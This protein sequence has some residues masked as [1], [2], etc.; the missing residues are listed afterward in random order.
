MKALK[1]KISRR[2]FLHGAALTTAGLAVAA[3]TSATPTAAPTSAPK[4]AEPSATTAPT[5][6][7]EATTAPT[8]AV[9]SS[10][11]DSMFPKG[12]PRR[13]LLDRPVPAPKKYDNL[14]ITQNYDMNQGIKFNGNDTISDNVMSRYLKEEIGVYYEPKWACK[15]SETCPTA[16]STAMAADDL[17]EFFTW[18]G[19][20]NLGKLLDA[21]RL[22]DIT[23]IWETTASDLTKKNKEYP[24][25]QIYV[26][27]TKG[28]R[29]Y[30]IP[31][32]NGGYAAHDSLLWVRQDW[33]DELGLKM[34]DTLDDLYNVAKAFK[35]KKQLTMGISAAGSEGMATWNSSLDPFFGAFGVMPTYWVKTGDGKLAYGSTLPGNT[36]ALTVLANWF[37]E[38]LIE[39]EFVTKG[40]AKAAENLAGN[41]A[42]MYF[43]PSWSPGW[44][45]PDSKKNDPK[46]DWVSGRVP[47]GP[48]GQR[49]RAAFQVAGSTCA[50][51][52]GID[53][54]KIEAVINHLNWI[55]DMQAAS[56]IGSH[57]KVE[58]I[59]Y[60]EENGE[61]KAG[62][63]TTAEFYE[64]G[65]GYPTW[66]YP[67]ME[68]M[69]DEKMNQLLKADPKTL[70]PY[71]LY[72]VNDPDGISTKTRAANSLKF[73]TMDD[74]IV[75]Q[76]IG[77]PTATMTEAGARLEKIEREAYIKII[78]GGAP[79]S[80]WEKF[81]AD[82]KSQGGDKITEEINAWWLSHQ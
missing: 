80:D 30:G 59:D 41:K 15:G 71:L 39:P 13:W 28:G 8:E 11:A 35:E 62:I 37:K 57:V 46:A 17:P 10:S 25:G 42:G 47:A 82:W 56:V 75:N 36:D 21:D 18:L 38:G 58:G 55:Y 70:N 16:W 60:V 69:T 64:G 2:A 78:T 22:E 14:V 63:G 48:T 81:V 77:A 19:G 54:I 40:A 12:D 5:Q 65:A 24:T 27:I 32:S 7:A 74:Q 6:A 79:V 26:P 23:D 49:G 20:V 9:A 33:L 61:V 45:L 44:P 29:I 4:P 34:P 43:A 1:T 31:F 53:P 52:K 72:T 67:A 51:L 76:F 66:Y 68:Q 73:Q 3:C 50:F